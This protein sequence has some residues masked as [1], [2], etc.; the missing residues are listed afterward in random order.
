MLSCEPIAK[1]LLQGENAI[2]S[3]HSAFFNP[4]NKV[5]L[6]LSSDPGCFLSIYDQSISLIVTIPLFAAT[7]NCLRVEL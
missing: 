6:I 7:A 1:K 3:I 2:V 4:L 5:I